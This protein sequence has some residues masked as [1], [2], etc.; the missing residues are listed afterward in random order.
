[1]IKD[2]SQIF[3]RIDGS[4]RP[5]SRTTIANLFVNLLERR[6][7]IKKLQVY[8]NLLR[9]EI[10]LM[11]Q[12]IDVVD[13]NYTG[14]ILL[15]DLQAFKDAALS[16]EWFLS[17]QNL[18]GK[19]HG[20]GTTIGGLYID[21]HELNVLNTTIAGFNNEQMNRGNRYSSFEP[22]LAKWKS[23]RIEFKNIIGSL[24]DIINCCTSR[25]G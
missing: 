11:A 17:E 25:H 19:V 20:S 24:D 5:A 8:S 21:M 13:N 6:N 12:V 7:S 18:L 9:N 2:T 23:H 3:V 10:I 16:A 4:T 1:M 14:I 15:F 22:V